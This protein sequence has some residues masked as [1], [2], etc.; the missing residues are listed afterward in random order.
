MKT[1]DLRRALLLA[2]TVGA[3]AAVPRPAAAQAA[4][5]SAESTSATAREL[6]A[7]G[8]QYTRAE[9]FSEAVEAFTRSLALVPRA[10]AS[11]NLAVVL[12]HLGRARASLRELERFHSLAEVD[13][14]DVEHARALEVELRARVAY[15]ELQV[16]PPD[17][18]L[19]VDG[20]ACEARGPTRLLDLDPGRHVVVAR[21]Q[22]FETG[23]DE[24][25]LAPGERL[26]HR[27]RLTRLPPPPVTTSPAELRSPALAPAGPPIVESPWLW[28]GVG[29]A[30]VALALGIGFGV[31]ASQPSPERCMYTG[32]LD[33]CLSL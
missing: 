18:S 10:S 28:L 25:H 7:R 17:A 32:A 26:P 2:A 27:L 15:L 3:I 8:V 33:V 29:L 22:G 16:A 20:E 5:D 14:P 30:A 23:R 12:A 13:G 1:G 24:V 9:R 11:F 31:D 21:A 4:P 19:E 6:F